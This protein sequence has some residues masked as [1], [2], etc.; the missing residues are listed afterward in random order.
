MYATIYR[1][2]EFIGLLVKS[3]S[4]QH[5]Y[6]V[7]WTTGLIS[8]WLLHIPRFLLLRL[9]TKCLYGTFCLLLNKLY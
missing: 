5:Y 9:L 2:V 1:L 8:F 3:I 4:V 6:Q 7:D